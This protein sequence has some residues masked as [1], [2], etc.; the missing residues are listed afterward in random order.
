MNGKFYKS[1]SIGEVDGGEK[2]NPLHRSEIENDELEQAIKV[3]LEIN[4]YLS[5]EG[6]PTKY[7][8][9]VFLLEV[10][11]PRQG[12]TI[13]ITTFIRYKLTDTTNNV[14]LFD[15]ICSASDTKTFGDASI[16]STRFIIAQGDSIKKNISQLL[17]LLY[18]MNNN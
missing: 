8:L 18:K 15:T 2:T 16:A 4:N 9:D 10:D 12:F 3:S 14:L 13:T 7:K 11:R 17:S 5:S 1:I 6:Y